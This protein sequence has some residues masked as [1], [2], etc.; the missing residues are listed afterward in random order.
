MIQQYDV[1]VIGTG[2]AGEGASMKLAKQGKRVA[3]VEMQDQ[4]GGNCTHKGTIPSKALR[5]AIQLLADYRQYPL[6][7]HTVNEMNVSWPMLLQASGR[8]V[9]QQV[10][11]RHRFYV[12]NGV[13]LFRGVARLRDAHTVAVTNNDGEVD[14]S[15]YSTT[16][17]IVTG[18]DGYTGTTGLQNR[19]CIKHNGN[20][21]IGTDNPAQKLTVNTIYVKK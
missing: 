10:G 20:V 15:G 3:V 7:G 5:H 13:A 9:D 19:M 1:V 11:L 8:V 4:V 16:T 21:G 18:S 17:G 2:P 6:F 12:R 14:G